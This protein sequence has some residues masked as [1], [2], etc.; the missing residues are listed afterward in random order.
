LKNIWS[1]I[2]AN[3]AQEIVSR[4]D[5]NDRILF[6]ILSFFMGWRLGAL[7][8]PFMRVGVIDEAKIHDR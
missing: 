1:P 6:T 8:Q 7:I 2:D 3:K 4:D 5:I